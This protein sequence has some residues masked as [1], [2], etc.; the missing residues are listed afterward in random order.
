MVNGMTSGGCEIKCGVPQGS[1]LGPLL[2]LV[3]MNDVENVIINSKIHLYADDM[4]ICISGRKKNRMQKWIQ[5]DL[6]K[7]T[8]WCISNKLSV[9][10]T[11][12]KY[13]IFSPKAKKKRI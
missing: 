11:K 1:V 5:K 7:V 13:M 12:T 2:F 6:E 8:D 9:N 4:V 3:Y 10:I